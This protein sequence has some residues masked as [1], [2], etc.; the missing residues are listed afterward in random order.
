MDVLISGTVTP[1]ST[2]TEQDLVRVIACLRFVIQTLGLLGV[3]VGSRQRSLNGGIVSSAAG[4]EDIRLTPFA[5]VFADAIAVSFVIHRAD[6][7]FRRIELCLCV[8]IREEFSAS[9]ALVAELRIAIL[10]AGCRGLR[11]LDQRIA[12]LRSGH[13]KSKRVFL[14]VPDTI[15]LCLQI[16]ERLVAEIAAGECDGFSRF[17]DGVRMRSVSF[18]AVFPALAINLVYRDLKLD[19]VRR[20]ALETLRHV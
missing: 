2:E 12:R 13:V 19:L 6:P 4:A 9:R 3:L 20:P 10:G 18:A 8:F 16:V 14:V 17:R 1:F 7:D 15:N 5:A 11:M